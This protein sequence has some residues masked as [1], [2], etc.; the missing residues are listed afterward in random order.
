MVLIILS[1]LLS[2]Q[3]WCPPLEIYGGNIVELFQNASDDRGFFLDHESDIE[4]ITNLPLIKAYVGTV[5][6]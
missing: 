2:Q 6:L 4:K 1:L 5:P 3:I